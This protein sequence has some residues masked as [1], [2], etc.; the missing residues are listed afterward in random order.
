MPRT[1]FS[2]PQKGTKARALVNIMLSPAGVTS[3]QALDRRLIRTARALKTLIMQLQCECGFDIL[4]SITLSSEG[5]K[6]RSYHIAGRH[7]WNGQ[8]RSTPKLSKAGEP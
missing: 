3:C 5:G 4:T 1:G 8:Y 2:T 7:R 6:I